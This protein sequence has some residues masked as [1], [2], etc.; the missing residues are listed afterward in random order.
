MKTCGNACTADVKT[1]AN[2]REWRNGRRKGLK[3]PRV[4]NPYRFESGLSHQ[5]TPLAQLVRARDL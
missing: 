3:I 1:Q 4:M 2:S 5:H